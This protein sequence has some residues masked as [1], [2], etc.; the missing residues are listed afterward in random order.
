MAVVPFPERFFASA[1]KAISVFEGLKANWMFIGAVPVAAWGRARA[2]TDADFAVSLELPDQ[3]CM[4]HHMTKAGVEKVSGPVEI[5]GKRLVLSKYW[6]PVP[7]GEGIGIDVFLATGYDVGRFLRDSLARKVAAR[8]HGKDYWVCPPEDLIL[9]KILAF[10]ARDVDDV[11]TV[12]EK[13][14]AT[15]D[16][17]HI[18]RWACELRLENLLKQIVTQYVDYAGL[19]GPLPWEV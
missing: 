8:F 17:K 2:T 5:P 10:R 15:L 13:R 3:T 11:A 4:D 1:A 7:E 18:H 16:W 6:A 12:L 14:Y 19:Q 9:L